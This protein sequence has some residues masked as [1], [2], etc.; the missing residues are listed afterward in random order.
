M[1]VIKEP[2]PGLLIIKPKVFE[3]ERGF[4]METWQKKLY[5]EIGIKDD[6]VQDNWSRSYK[7]VLRGLH[8][9]KKHPQGKLVSVRSGKVF[10]VAVDIRNDSP[11]FGKW[12]GEELTDEN[13]FQMFVP[14]G[15]AHG[16]C[17]LSE[18]AD[19]VYKCT[20]YY[21]PN[22]EDGIIWNDDSIGINWPLK[23]PIVSN[24]DNKLGSFVFVLK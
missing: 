10:D 9:Q 4:F 23:N 20:D 1:E 21:Y 8:F 22:Y 24:K 14:P 3:D 15:F 17:V 11:T 18:T 6:F 5:K 13:H 16:F 19:F 2:I 12:Y 7:G